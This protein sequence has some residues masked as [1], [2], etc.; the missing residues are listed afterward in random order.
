M[1]KKYIFQ[2][3]RNTE[4]N[5]ERSLKALEVTIKPARTKPSKKWTRENVG[6]Y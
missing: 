5:D 3:E 2:M 4:A 1:K 6:E